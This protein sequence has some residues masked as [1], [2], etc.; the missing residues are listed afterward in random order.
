MFAI[1]FMDID[2]MYGMFAIEFM[3]I[4]GLILLQNCFFL[5]KVS[6]TSISVPRVDQHIMHGAS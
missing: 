6:I 5:G 4:Y 3:D 1:E 2:G